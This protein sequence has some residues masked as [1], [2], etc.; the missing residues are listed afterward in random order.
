MASHLSPSSLSPIDKLPYDAL[1]EIFLHCVPTYPNIF[2]HRFEMTP[3]IL[4]HVCS[5]W[6]I[7]A[8]TS[9]R[10]WCY[11]S[12]SVAT[13]YRHGRWMVFKQHVDL[14]RLWRSKHGIIPPFIHIHIRSPELFEE[15][16]LVDEDAFSFILEYLA[17]AQYLEVNT[18]IW[19]KLATRN[20]ACPNLRV[21]ILQSDESDK[22]GFIH[23]LQ[24][25]M[26]LTV[27]PPLQRLSML[28]FTLFQENLHL[29]PG[30]WS[31]LTHIAL[32]N[33][34]IS[35][36]FWF[37][38]VRVV[39]S[40]R[41]AYLGVYNIEVDYENSIEY[42]LPQLCSFFIESRDIHVCNLFSNLYLPM[43]HTLSLSLR[44]IS[45]WKELED[46]IAE[47]PMILKRAPSIT[48]LGLSENLI[49][50]TD[51]WEGHYSDMGFPSTPEP[52]IG[53]TPLWTHTPHLT[54]FLFEKFFRLGIEKIS[55]CLGLYRADCPIRKLTVIDEELWDATEDSTASQNLEISE[56]GTE[57]E[58]NIIVE[59]DAEA[60][61]QKARDASKTWELVD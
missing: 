14:I 45:L 3:I 48:T 23:N 33:I 15:E 16:Q 9:P 53:T 12:Q 32:W 24:L 1:R 54:H 35:L 4:S 39:P 57:L 7:V 18:I 10:L 17:S 20:I 11:L 51:V 37:N 6:R 40:L 43:L 58:R 47:M 49:R 2:D 28:C 41:W 38:F 27:T 55:E 34:T 52:S 56:H 60:L 22:G 29:S 30:P 36:R 8:H 13:E 25:V 31:S 61:H 46:A 19:D 44:G 21:V 42:T 5:S 26:G 59:F 50:I